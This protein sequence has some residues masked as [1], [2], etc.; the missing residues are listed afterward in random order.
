MISVNKYPLEC[1]CLTP[2][3]VSTFL[4]FPA[5]L[6]ECPF[7]LRVEDNGS[8]ERFGSQAGGFS[9]RIATYWL[10]TLGRLTDLPG[11]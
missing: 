2:K 5:E 3:S 9:H 1:V 4:S 6:P 11:P 7:F 8:N 10:V